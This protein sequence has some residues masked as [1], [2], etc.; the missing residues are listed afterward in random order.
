MVR[1][2]AP[3]TEILLGIT[4]PRVG[5]RDSGYLVHVEYR[6]RV[7]TGGTGLREIA[8]CLG[9]EVERG[10]VMYGYRSVTAIKSHLARSAPRRRR[11]CCGEGSRGR[12]RNARATAALRRRFDALRATP[13][14]AHPS[15]TNNA[16]L[17]HV[18]LSSYPLRVDIV[19]N[20][21]SLYDRYV[22]AQIYS[23]RRV[24]YSFS[25]CKN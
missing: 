11:R 15:P 23:M 17:S 21:V 3:L 20:P 7:G 24:S 14:R 19:L 4:P 16:A 10:V 2:I 8:G 25:V 6:R 22:K 13:L 1:Y 18:E 5:T 12:Q 9:A